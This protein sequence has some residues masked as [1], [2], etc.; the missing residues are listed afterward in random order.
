MKKFDVLVVGEL[1]VDLIFNRI[2]PLPEVGKEVLAEQ[3]TLTLGSS[4]AIFASNLSSL[5]SN[6]GFIGKIGK[7]HFGEFILQ[8]LNSKGVDTSHI[9]QS[10]DLQTGATVV[11]NFGEDRAMVTHPGAMNHLGIQDIQPE[12]LAQA[13]HL[14]FSS[15]FLQSGIQEE[16][17]Q[18]FQQAKNLGLSTSFDT[19]WDPSEKW[20]VKLS[21]ILPFVDVF[22]PNETEFLH[23]TGKHEFTEAIDSVKAFSNTIVVKR[24]NK[25]SVSWSKGRLLYQE[26]FL[27]RDVVDAIGAGDS[28]NAGFIHKFI[29]KSDVETCQEY[30]NLIGAISTTAVGGTSAFADRNHF[31]R[32]AKEKFGYQAHET[33]R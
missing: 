7:D 31:T 16:V 33:A 3:M 30:G 25:G 4:S 22:L 13:R 5:G 12:Q 27:N 26:P 23:L 29:Q 10:K 28:F 9:K 15:F 32:I 18:L 8:S 24:G 19:Q 1:N 21:S 6:V 20:D 14:H 11:L 2:N 17:Q